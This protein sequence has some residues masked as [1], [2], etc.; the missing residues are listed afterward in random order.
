MTVINT[1]TAND[2]HLNWPQCL[3]VVICHTTFGSLH[4]SFLL[5]SLF[6]VSSDILMGWD[7]FTSANSSPPIRIS[8]DTQIKLFNNCNIKPPFQEK[9]NCSRDLYLLL[10]EIPIA[11]SMDSYKTWNTQRVYMISFNSCHFCFYNEHN[12]SEP[13]RA[14]SHQ[15]FLPLK[16]TKLAVKEQFP[17]DSAIHS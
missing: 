9:T 14:K 6:W 16:R 11:T 5:N 4:T 3:W 8:H 2:Q 15:V 12:L 10:W 7:S 17:N 13:D 1:G